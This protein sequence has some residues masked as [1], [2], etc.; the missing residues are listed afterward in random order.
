MKALEWTLRIALFGE[1]LGHGIFALRAVPHFQELMAGSLGISTEAAA[2]VLPVIGMIDFVVAALA[3]VYPIRAVLIY[4][5]LW[6]L[7]TGLARPVSGKEIWDF[8]E[9]W[10]NWGIP[11]A[12]LLVR[13][14][15][16]TR[17][18]WLR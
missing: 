15:P 12:L 5:A 18:D 13:G 1:F 9:R 7:L 11:L 10:P 6:G 14:W 4:A 17:R 2:G 3:L 8:V 16:R